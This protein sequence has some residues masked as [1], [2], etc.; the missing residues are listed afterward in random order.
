MPS[1]IRVSGPV[2]VFVAGGYLGTAET[3]PD[4]QETPHYEG[5]M[6]TIAGSQ[7]PMEEIFQ[8]L[9]LTISMIL[10]RYDETVFAG[11]R[12]APLPINAGVPGNESG[13]SRGATMYGRFTGQLILQN[14]FFG[15]ANALPGDF[16][17]YRFL[18]AKYAGSK[19]IQGGTS[20]NKL[21]IVFECKSVYQPST[22]TFQCYTND[23]AISALTPN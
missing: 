2:H 14:S 4:Y 21:A 6:N 9:D 10:T 19:P 8:G 22:R 16:P 18:Y 11:I 15:T 23:A 17:G 7:V 5:V 13:L 20:A 3:T 12:T 1:L